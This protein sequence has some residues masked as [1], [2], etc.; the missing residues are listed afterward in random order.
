MADR[1]CYCGKGV[2]VWR[3]PSW[4]PDIPLYIRCDECSKKYEIKTTPGG[5]DSRKGHR[6]DSDT[7]IVEK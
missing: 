3:E 5:I 1:P 6:Y 4:G 7:R 2:I